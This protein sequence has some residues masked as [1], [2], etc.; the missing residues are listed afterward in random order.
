MNDQ[1]S[2]IFGIILVFIGSIL[3]DG[4]VKVNM[5]DLLQSITI[6]FVDYYKILSEDE[7]IIIEDVIITI[8]GLVMFIIGLEIIKN[9]SKISY[10]YNVKEKEYF[11][12]G[13]GGTAGVIT[14]IIILPKVNDS[15]SMVGCVSGIVGLIGFLTE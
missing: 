15:G 11:A 14:N 5:I 1:I 8:I 7:S 4:A 12:V 3:F 9:N 10:T 13:I 2:I 6:I